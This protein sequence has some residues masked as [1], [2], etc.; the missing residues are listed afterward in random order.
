MRILRER[1]YGDAE[2]NGQSY[3]SAQCAYVRDEPE[4]DVPVD[5][6][7][8]RNGKPALQMQHNLLRC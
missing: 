2:L 8:G 4:V 1:I 3:C 7:A 5:R 6:T